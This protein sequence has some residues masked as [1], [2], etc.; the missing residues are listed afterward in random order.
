MLGVLCCAR[1]SCDDIPVLFIVARPRQQLFVVISPCT[2]NRAMLPP[3]VQVWLRAGSGYGTDLMTSSAHSEG[4]MDTAA[5]GPAN[6]TGTG[7]QWTYVATRQCCVDH[8]CSQTSWVS[9]Y[10]TPDALGSS[11]IVGRY[12]RANEVW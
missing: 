11:A 6:A 3:C 10:S 1:R 4:V 12:G 2:A 9:R 5:F 8:W 7:S